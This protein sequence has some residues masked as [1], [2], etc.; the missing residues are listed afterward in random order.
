MQE[1]LDFG[2][3]VEQEVLGG[4]EP[5][6][7]YHGD[8]DGHYGMIR[9]VVNNQRPLKVGDNFFTKP[10]QASDEPLVYSPKSG[11]GYDYFDPVTGRQVGAPNEELF[12]HSP[13]SAA[14]IARQAERIAELEEEGRHLTRML[15]EELC[16]ATFMGEP[17]IKQTTAHAMASALMGWKLPD[18]FAPD[19]GI[20]FKA[21]ENKEWWPTGTNLFDV[22]QATKMFKYVL[23]KA[24]IEPCAKCAA[25]EKLS[26]QANQDHLDA[27][28]RLQEKVTK[29]TAA[30]DDAISPLED[31]GHYP[32]TLAA[33]KEALKGEK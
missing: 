6:A 18:S 21:P 3:A 32:K 1:I 30:L 13:D 11:G 5:V 16:G 26:S 2:R 17:V 33:I 4:S 24:G 15:N 7:V 8:H 22:S 10:Q 20:S 27:R 23:D 12:T 31:S 19:A 28:L 29:L 14:E 25:L 9:Y